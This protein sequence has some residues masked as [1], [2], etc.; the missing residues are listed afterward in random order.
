M[1]LMTDFILHL[2]KT[3]LLPVKLTQCETMAT[4]QQFILQ[5]PNE[6]TI[7]FILSSHKIKHVQYKISTGYFPFV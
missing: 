1:R 5:Q 2:H 4:R 3:A 6:I 7:F